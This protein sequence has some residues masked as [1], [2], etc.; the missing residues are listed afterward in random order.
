MRLEPTGMPFDFLGQRFEVYDDSNQ[1]VG[2]VYAPSQDAKGRAVRPWG[3]MV[4]GVTFIS[5][6]LV[7]AGIGPA[8]GAVSGAMHDSR[9]PLPRTELDVSSSRP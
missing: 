3:A 6:L 9:P 8:A 2:A 7:G 1:L 5:G 4:L